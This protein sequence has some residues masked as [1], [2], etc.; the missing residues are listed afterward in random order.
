MCAIDISLSLQWDFVQENLLFFI[1]PA[2][3]SLALK[4]CLIWFQ[5]VRKRIHKFLR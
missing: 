4:A 1:I 5:L 3:V 2:E